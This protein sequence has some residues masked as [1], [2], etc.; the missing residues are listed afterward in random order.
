VATDGRHIFFSSFNCQVYSLDE[1]GKQRWSFKTGGPIRSGVSVGADQVFVGSDDGHVYALHKDSGKK[2]WSFKTDGFVEA[3]PAI[4]EQTAY[5]GSVD[6]RFRALSL[7]TGK[8]LWEIDAASPIRQPALI[9]GHEVYF[10]SDNTI[11]RQ[12]EKRTGKVISETKFNYRGLTG[13]TPV[14]NSILFGTRSGYL[15]VTREKK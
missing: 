10:Y 4:D 5:I 11:L 7:Q 8:L 13:M 12:V 15:T 2:A 14:G 1:N 3:A 6:G 9:V